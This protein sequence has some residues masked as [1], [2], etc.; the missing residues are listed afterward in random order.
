MTANPESLLS[1][2]RAGQVY[3]AGF[4]KLFLMP[5]DAWRKTGLT[6]AGALNFVL[7]GE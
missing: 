4:K 3:A 7:S 5:A 6:S 2:R 1:R